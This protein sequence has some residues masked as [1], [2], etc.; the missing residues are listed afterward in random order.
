MGSDL[1]QRIVESVKYTWKAV[2][3]FAM[4]HKTNAP[5]QN[6]EEEVDSVLNQMSAAEKEDD[7]ACKYI[8]EFDYSNVWLIFLRS[9]V[10]S[11]YNEFW[12]FKCR[13]NLF[14]VHCG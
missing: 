10:G 8:M 4:A 6:V 7:V 14:T 5:V 12:L 2:N 9:I 13:T 1:K 11:W 3:D